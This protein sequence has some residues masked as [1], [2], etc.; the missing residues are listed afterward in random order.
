[1]KYP[2]LPEAV[3]ALTRAQSDC[4][5]LQ[6]STDEVL[7]EAQQRR[8]TAMRRVAAVGVSHGPIGELTGLSPTRVN[9]IPRNGRAIPRSSLGISAGR[10]SPVAQVAVI[11]EP[12]G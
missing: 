10:R 4:G 6:A 2:V 3:P 7:A 1:M 12:A 9:Q 11:P 8:E 5:A